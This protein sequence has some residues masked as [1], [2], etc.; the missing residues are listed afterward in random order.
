M[1]LIYQLR[2]DFP[3][4]LIQFVVNKGT[5]TD[6]L[7]RE[8]Q[9]YLRVD[10]RLLSLGVTEEELKG[11]TLNSGSGKNLY[12]LFVRYMMD[13]FE[14]TPSQGSLADQLKITL[15]EEQVLRYLHKKTWQE[16]SQNQ[17]KQISRL[18]P[19][20]PPAAELLQLEHQHKELPAVVE[21][22]IG[23]LGRLGRGQ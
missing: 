20:L 13:F 5:Q 8:Y 11:I 4:H 3:G 14:V 23:G 10:N 22:N 21:V 17:Q 12:T 9:F 2:K 6:E 15:T 1:E 16:Q 18:P 7:H 19:E